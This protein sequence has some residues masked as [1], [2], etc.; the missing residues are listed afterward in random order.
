MPWGAADA[1]PTRLLALDQ[2]C[3]SF[4]L[5]AFWTLYLGQ[6]RLRADS[7]GGPG[8][9]WAPSG[10]EPFLSW[11]LYSQGVPVA[12]VWGKMALV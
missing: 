7:F 12:I 1:D 4:E 5:F 8:R 6:H 9:S 2:D 10:G 11:L 3:S